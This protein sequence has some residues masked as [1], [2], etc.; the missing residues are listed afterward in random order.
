MGSL[1]S[2]LCWFVGVG[3][4]M[5]LACSRAT[6]PLCLALNM[7]TRVGETRGRRQT[8]F[9]RPRLGRTRTFIAHFVLSLS[10]VTLFARTVALVS[11]WRTVSFA[12]GFLYS[13]FNILFALSWLFI[14]AGVC[15]ARCLFF[16]RGDNF[17]FLS[18]SRISFSGVSACG[19][20][21]A[22]VLF[23]DLVWNLRAAAT[24]DGKGVRSGMALYATEHV[25]AWLFYSPVSSLS[26]LRRRV[27]V[28]EG[29]FGLR[30]VR[31]ATTLH[32]T[33]DRRAFLGTLAK[34]NAGPPISPP[35]HAACKARDIS[36]TALCRYRCHLFAC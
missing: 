9:G 2:L 30:G 17:N 20:P 27:A 3:R 5:P 7:E 11:G 18:L 33:A 24:P 19:I 34:D 21:S 1:F 16:S 8:P 23:K 14:Y 29:R 12:S 25:A 15:A 28:V 6:V 10:V 31:R 4:K 26:L 32:G 22:G 13:P 35:R 36:R